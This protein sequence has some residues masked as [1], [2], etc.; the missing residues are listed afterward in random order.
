[1]SV[2]HLSGVKSPVEERPLFLDVKPGMTVI[3]RCEFQVGQKQDKDWWMGVV[4]WCEG[5]AR[6]PSV[7]SLFQVEDVDTGVIHWVNADQVTHIVPTNPD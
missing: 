5:G 3:V 7:N 4:V 6:D 2:D 1:M